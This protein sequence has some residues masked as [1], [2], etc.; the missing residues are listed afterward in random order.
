MHTHVAYIIHTHTHL[1]RMS[2]HD[3]LY[4]HVHTHTYNIHD[5]YIRIINIHD[6]YI[7]IYM[8][9]LTVKEGAEESRPT[10]NFPA[11]EAWTCQPE[12]HSCT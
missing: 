7:Y 4:I 6:I 8:F 2:R 12:V 3:V 1:K 9:T 10:R 11:P 5:I